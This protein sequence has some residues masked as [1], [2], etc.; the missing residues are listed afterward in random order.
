MYL[1]KLNTIST[2]NVLKGQCIGIVYMVKLFKFVMQRDLIAR[3]KRSKIVG[4]VCKV[5]F[6]EG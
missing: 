1:S 2:G 6:C 4:K 3:R 5:Y